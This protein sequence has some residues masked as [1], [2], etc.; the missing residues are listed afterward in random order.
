MSLL[1]I[2]VGAASGEFSKHILKFNATANVYMIEPNHEVNQKQLLAIM[3]EYKS[4]TK[5]FPI[6]LGNR[7]GKVNFY[8]ST[9]LQGQI[10]SIYKINPTKKWDTSIVNQINFKAIN[11]VIEI[12]MV[13]VEQFLK[14]NAI[15]KI[16]FLKIDTQGN[17]LNILES[18][19][20][21]SMVEC[22]VV[23]VNVSGRT[24]DEIY[25]G[26]ENS[27]KRIFD[28]STKYDYIMYK[29]IPNVDLTE[30]NVFLCKNLDIGFKTLDDLQISKSET[31]GRYWRVLGIG[32]TYF[33]E[34]NLP[35]LLIKKFL[36]SF[37]HP[38]QSL[39]SAINKIVR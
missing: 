24:E 3:E 31:F 6:A 33:S 26:T 35:K 5:Y 14:Q 16:D 2:D 8:G 22:A 21:N 32:E 11:D 28:I 29:F 9:V 1:I 19:L 7:N 39:K 12:S 34:D 27:M 38:R 13:S 30:F 25:L 17:D 37:L 15:A 23:E 36:E 20:T 10:G 4:R 18:F